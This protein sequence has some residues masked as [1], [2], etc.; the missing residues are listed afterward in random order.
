MPVFQLEL[1]FDEKGAVNAVRQ[2]GKVSDAAGKAQ[3]SVKKVN[4]SLSDTGKSANEAADGLNRASVGLEKTSIQAKN[5]STS[6]SSLKNLLKG[7]AAGFAA[8]WSLSALNQARSA[9][10]KIGAEAQETSNRFNVVFSSV[11]AQANKSTEDLQK[12]YGMSRISAQASLSTIGDLLTGL[13]ISQRKALEL[14]EQATKL[15]AD[16]AKFTNYAG[17]AAGA[18]DALSRAMLGETSAAKALN[19]ALDD[20]LME[21]YAASVGKAWKSMDLA[22]KAELRL[23]AAIKQSPNA[24]GDYARS[25]DSYANQIRTAESAI[26][27]FRSTI[28]EGLIPVHSEALKAANSQNY[29]LREL[30]ETISGGLLIEGRELT[31]WLQNL[32]GKTDN[33]SDSVSILSMTFVSLVGGCKAVWN[34]LQLVVKGLVGV[35]TFLKSGVEMLADYTEALMSLGKLDFSGAAEK[36]ASANARIPNWYEDY[37]KDAIQD[38][39]EMGDALNMTFNPAKFVNNARQALKALRQETQQT[40]GQMVRNTGSIGKFGGG[41]KGQSQIASAQEHIKKLREEIDRLNGTSVK[42]VTSL[43]QKLR[44]IETVGKKAGMSADA[45]EQLQGEYQTAF[46][47][48][49]LENFNKELLQAQGNTKALRQIEIDDAIRGWEQQFKAAGVS[50]AEAQPKIEALRAALEKKQDYQDLQTAVGFYDELAQLS[51]D[52]TAS[53]E[54]QN[55][56]IALKAEIYRQNGIPPALVAEWE[57]L[58][59]IE[60]ARDPWSG[61]DRSVRKFYASATDYARGFEEVST[62]ALTGFSSTLT[63][64]LWKGEQD[65]GQFSQS[66]GQMITELAIQASMAQII[67]GG[68]GGGG[69]MGLLGGLFN[70]G[71]GDTFSSAASATTGWVTSAHGN[72]F[73]APGLSAHSNTIVDE[74]TFFGYDRH[75]TAFA[76]GAGLMGEAGPEAVMPLSRMSGGDLGVKVMWPDDMMRRVVEMDAWKANVGYS[77]E[78]MQ[79]IAKMNEMRAE[80]AAAMAGAP[81][82]NV[83]IINQAGAEVKTSQQ[84][85]SDGGI[86]LKIMMLKEV[87][88]D[89]DRRGGFNNKVLRNQFGAS[90]RPIKY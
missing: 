21:K 67:G 5:V 39:K 58:Q 2:L 83:T 8:A 76:S 66:I 55:E 48:N 57:L 77:Q 23:Q 79:A 25:V 49:A 35:G 42:A 84:P 41:S 73:S 22:Q 70:G 52:F 89:T 68:S 60:K 4:E 78:M 81:K 46:K 69:L 31:Q 1:Q 32:V 36:A 87:A 10:V 7:L 61:L 12:F 45:I 90:K 72:V 64:L 82:V 37:S 50:A 62:Q 17:G 13:G 26:E 53:L 86:D 19:L 47:S 24:L 15:G 56:L 59:K 9:L 18:V 28:G 80:R 43:D 38:F 40:A 75:L 54:K 29:A 34:G 11:S 30:S 20:T 16:L 6:F 44:E 51:G 14:A 63:Y 71:W 27:D 88:R 33:A 3:E 85:N 74:P 65:F